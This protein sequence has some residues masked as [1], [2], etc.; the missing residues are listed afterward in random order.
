MKWRSLAVTGN[1][2]FYR[3]GIW[4]FSGKK[5]DSPEKIFQN[6]FFIVAIF[7]IFQKKIFQNFFFSGIWPP[8]S[9]IFF[10]SGIF[11]FFWNI[12]SPPWNDTISNIVLKNNM[13]KMIIVNRNNTYWEK[14]ISHRNNLVENRQVYFENLRDYAFTCHS[15]ISWI[16]NMKVRRQK[17]VT[18]ENDEARMTRKK[19]RWM[20]R[21]LI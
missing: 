10:F 21:M 16:F 17:S 20:T 19:E 5:N 11:N 3:S 9:R 18:A 14:Y 13:N 2:I 1:V 7:A 15:H 4:P 12:F 8:N 6:S